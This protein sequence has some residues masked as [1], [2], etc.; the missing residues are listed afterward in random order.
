MVSRIIPFIEERAFIFFV[1]TI[2]MRDYH[3]ILCRSTVWQSVPIRQLPSP[4][5]DATAVSHDRSMQCSFKR[6]I[7]SVQSINISSPFAMSTLRASYIA[8]HRRIEDK[9]QKLITGLVVHR[10]G[11]RNLIY[12]LHIC[13]V[14]A[15]HCP[16]R[17]RYHCA[18]IFCTSFRKSRIVLALQACVLH[19]SWQ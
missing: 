14:C 5:D 17:I 6:D 15:L 7:Y 8:K 2:M 13:H 4:S 1:N 18:L 12:H 3:R 11:Y 10:K 19:E 9:H 16:K